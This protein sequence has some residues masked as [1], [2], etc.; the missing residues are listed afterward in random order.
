MLGVGGRGPDGWRRPTPPRPP[1]SRHSDE[2]MAE[3]SDEIVAEAVA[4]PGP[5]PADAVR[6]R[7]VAVRKIDI[8]RQS[9][10]TCSR[11][12][13]AARAPPGPARRDG[14]GGPPGPLGPPPAAQALTSGSGP[15]REFHI[16]PMFDSAGPV[17]GIDPGVSRCGYGAVTGRRR[18]VAPTLTA[19]RIRTGADLP[20]PERLG[21]GELARPWW[22]SCGRR[23]WPSSGC[24]S[25]STCARPC[26]WA[27]PAGWPCAAGR[28]GG[29]PVAQVQPER[30]EARGGQLR[31]RGEGRGAGHGGPAV[32][33]RGAAPARPMPPTRSP[34][35]SATSGKRSCADA[36]GAG[37]RPPGAR[38]RSRHHSEGG[39]TR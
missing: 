39:A 11:W 25:R 7:W 2:A 20:L 36:S 14:R 31:R 1:R 29:V 3:T 4:R 30:G 37:R 24:S 15:S 21:R 27:R 32:E 26:R 6:Q 17:L 8:R 38:A 22:P 28:A 12:G 35:R 23:Q 18:P 5:E 9:R 10:S 33:P 34:S 19:R 16:E 13:N